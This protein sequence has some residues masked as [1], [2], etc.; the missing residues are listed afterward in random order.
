MKKTIYI[1][2]LY[3]YGVKGMK[4]GVRIGTLS[5]EYHTVEQTTLKDFSSGGTSS[6]ERF[7]RET[8]EWTPAKKK[9]KK[10]KLTR[11]TGKAK[12]VEGAVGKHRRKIKNAATARRKTQ[13][14]LSKIK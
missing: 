8:R 11:A 13:A 6:D 7:T 2:E 9:K 4:R 14:I 12:L 1:D 5:R 3:H 10:L